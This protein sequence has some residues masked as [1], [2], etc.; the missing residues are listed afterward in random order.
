VSIFAG[1]LDPRIAIVER[2]IGDGLAASFPEEEAAVARAVAKRRREFLAGRNAAH[3]AL[4]K[5]GAPRKPLLPGPDRMPLWPAGYV[6]SITHTDCHCAVAVGRADDGVRAIGIDLEPAETLP[7]GVLETIGRAEEIAW[8]Q[9]AA[10]NKRDLL[11][12]A[13]FSAKECTFKCQ[14]PVTRE[15]LEFEDLSI[16]IDLS[17]ETFKATFERDAGE[18]PRGHTARGR[19]RVAN[20]LLASA[21]ALYC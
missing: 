14:F 10:R 4:A 5:L 8:L 6:G 3:D 13:L 1:L 20:G 2:A 11:A 12:R 7:P 16:E 19:I 18:F 15:M 21:I 17:A 9:S